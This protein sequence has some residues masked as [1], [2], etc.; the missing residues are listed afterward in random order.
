[1]SELSAHVDQ[2]LA[3]PGSRSDRGNVSGHAVRAAGLVLAGSVLRLV[4]LGQLVACNKKETSV[5][6]L[7][8]IGVKTTDKK[9]CMHMF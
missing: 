3:R 6:K 1:M 7:F 5:R 2:R 4:L 8:L 9:P